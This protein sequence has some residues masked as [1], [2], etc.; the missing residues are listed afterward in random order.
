MYKEKQV[1]VNDITI[2][3]KEWP[4]ES[5]KTLLCL[6]G[7]LDNAS[8]FDLLAPYLSEFTVI[9]IDLPGHG[10]SEHLPPSSFYHFIDGISHLVSM[11][12]VLGLKDFI[13]MGHSL[14][15]CLASMAAPVLQK[16]LDKLILIDA[17]GPLTS[18]AQESFTHYQDYLNKLPLLLKKPRRYYSSI[19]EAAR[20]RAQKGY[21]SFE[22][23]KI[24]ASRGLKHDEK[25]YTWAHDDRLLLPSPLRMTEEQV[26]P[27]LENI[28]QPSLLISAD[29]GFQYDKGKAL[30]RF[31]SV[32]SLTVAELSGGHHIHLESPERCAKTIKPFIQAKQAES[33]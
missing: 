14:G 20:I 27:F 11:I 17:L 8:S 29:K 1:C 28:T 22:L 7:W 33:S 2:A 21:L 25:G 9:A 5:D 26:L 6:H 23:T 19:D 12:K 15:G 10:L 13:L 24:I 3:Y 30:K 18:T 32:P 16:E 4:G 31:E